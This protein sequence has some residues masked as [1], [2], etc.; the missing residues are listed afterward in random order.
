LKPKS[1]AFSLREDFFVDAVHLP[2]FVGAAFNYAN[3][4]ANLRGNESI[5]TNSYQVGVYGAW[6]GAH[7]FAQGFVG[8]GVQQYRNMR[9]GVVDMIRSNPTGSSLIAG[10]KVGYLFDAGPFFKIG[11]I[12]GVTYARADIKGFTESGDPALVLTIGPQKVDTVVGSAGAQ[13]RYPVIFNNI[14]WNPYLNLNTG[15]CN[16]G[17]FGSDDRMDYTII[18]AEANLAARLQAIAEPGGICLSYETYAVVRDLVR[19]T[20]GQAI[21]MKG[22]SRK[23]VPYTVEGL[24][25]EL[26]QRPEVISEYGTGLDLFLDVAAMD[27]SAMERARKRLGEALSA[28]TARAK[29]A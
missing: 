29:P 8:G 15:Y 22:I 9:F 18:G 27:E 17:N 24:L 23:V 25:G 5:D 7:L 13:I 20:P 26:T 2:S 12:V 14:A 6:V 10:G 16:V 11:P 28:V 4:S 19:A 21:A 1:P 3:P